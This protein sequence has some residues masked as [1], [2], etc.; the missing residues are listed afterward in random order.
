LIELEETETAE[1]F[2]RVRVCVCVCGR[3]WKEKHFPRATD[4]DVLHV[5]NQ[6]HYGAAELLSRATRC[7]NMTL[8]QFIWDGMGCV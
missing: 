7:C 2:A 8:L 4:C 1:R 5:H 6:P 3:V